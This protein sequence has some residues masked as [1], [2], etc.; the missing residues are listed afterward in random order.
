MITTEI[1]FI[2]QIIKITQIPQTIIISF[3]T[4]K[5][6]LMQYRKLVID[7]HLSQNTSRSSTKNTN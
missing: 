6:L 1:I 2:K 3:I 4:Y 7:K 5:F